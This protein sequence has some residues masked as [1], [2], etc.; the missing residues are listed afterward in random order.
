MFDP[1]S[2]QTWPQHRYK[3]VRREKM[4]ANEPEIVLLT[5]YETISSVSL[6]PPCYKSS[7]IGDDWAIPGVFD[8]QLVWSI[9]VCLPGALDPSAIERKTSDI[10]TPGPAEP[11]MLSRFW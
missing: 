1:L 3:R 2:G 11:V 5:N 10:G 9:F 4:V 8:I 7:K 6:Q